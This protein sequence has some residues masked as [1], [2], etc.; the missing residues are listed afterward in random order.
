[1]KKIVLLVYLFIISFGLAPLFSSTDQSTTERILT[2]NKNFIEFINICITNFA[3]NKTEDY[4]K[5][6]AKHFNADIAYLQGDYK[7]A[8]K[9][10]YS[11]QG[12]MAKIFDEIVKNIYLEDSKNIL[13]E[14]APGVIKSKNAKA[15]LYLSLGY[16]DRTVSWTYYI[17][18]EASNPKLFSYKIY[19]YLDAIDMARR[20]KRY[21]FLALF[22]SQNIESKK[23]IYQQMLK[24]ENDKGNI[25]Y[26]RFIGK[27]DQALLDELA[28][29]YEDIEKSESAVDQQPADKKD[30]KASEKEKEKTAVFEKKVEKRIRFK[31]EKKTA[32][33][34]ANG[35]F[36]KAADIMHQYV[37]DYNYKLILSTFKALSSADQPPKDQPSK[38]QPPKDQPAI[39]GDK[40]AAKL[41]FNKYA[42][43]LDD[44]YLRMIK[45]SVLESLLGTVKV[46][47]KVDVKKDSKSEKEAEQGKDAVKD[48]KDPDKKETIEKKDNVQPGEKKEPVKEQVK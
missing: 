6:F 26:K 36:E 4:R 33:F 31:Q 35:E 12:D 7:R 11:S 40:T 39:D 16:R 28:K 19:K 27:N 2:E 15:R 23:K 42:V 47:D 22:E 5:I 1:M 44:N 10:I 3:G 20:A 14:L 45:P 29:S 48:V 9:N 32:E 38:D 41:D 43:H 37:E 24:V 46:E 21:G 30:E 25:F 17:I 18:G 8:F 13:D 34:I